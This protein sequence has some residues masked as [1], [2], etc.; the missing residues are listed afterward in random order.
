MFPEK[1]FTFQSWEYIFVKF[2]TLNEIGVN[3]IPKEISQSSQ[4]LNIYFISLQI[5]FEIFS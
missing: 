5:C 4:V 3:M 1:I 2:I